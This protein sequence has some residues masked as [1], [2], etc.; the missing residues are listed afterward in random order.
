MG[1]IL[2]ISRIKYSVIA[3]L[4]NG[5]EVYLDKVATNIAWEENES[6][7]A[8]RLNLTVRDV[9]IDGTR[10][11]LLLDLGSQVYVFADYG[12]GMKE[13]FRGTFWE[14]KHSDVHDDEV[15]LTAYDA[16]YY[17]QKSDHYA[18]YPAGKTTEEVCKDILES[19]SVPFVFNA[20]SI[21]HEKLALKTKKISAMLTE[22]LDKAYL[23]LGVKY[24]IRATKGVCEILGVGQN[25]TIWTFSSD[26]NII[27]AEDKWSMSNM[28]TKVVIIGKDDTNGANKPPVEAVVSGR[29]E[30]GTLQ[31]IMSLGSKTV[32]EA[33]T[34]ANQTLAQKSWPER[35]LKLIAPDFPEIRK[36]DRIRVVTSILN[37]YFFVMS[38]SHNATTQ[39]M[40]M[41]VIADESRR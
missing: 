29:T 28:V 11:S 10:L 4:T 30:Y 32:D 36:G 9:P 1:E 25:E 34:E 12:T 8:T 14:W 27:T 39:Q 38:I 2:D 41:E 5:K 7:L 19:W 20:P 6:E 16:L 37:R 18:L 26:S 13:V 33:Q 22:V 21:V 24:V 40:Q 17:L 3:M 31:K 15:V 23:R 35:K